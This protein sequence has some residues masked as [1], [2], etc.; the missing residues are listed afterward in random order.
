MSFHIRPAVTSDTGAIDA[1]LART[2]PKLLKADYP[3]SVLVTALPKMI[4]AQPALIASGSF[5]V[6]EEEDGALLGAGGWTMAI[7]GG[8]GRTQEG[9]ANVRHVVTSDRA[10]KRG[11]GRAIME[12]SFD[13]ARAAG[14]NWMHCMATRTA[15]PFYERL[16][17]VLMGE[18]VVSFGPGVEFP[19]VEMRRDL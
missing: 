7:P 17:F 9:R 5:Y 14:A 13:K 3:P 1:L 4:K 6:A 19:S 15:V 12:H 16:G 2:Y 10:L 8:G 11:V 18:I